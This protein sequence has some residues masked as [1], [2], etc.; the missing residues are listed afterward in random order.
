MNVHVHVLVHEIA[1]MVSVMVR[2]YEKW[3]GI[4]PT[5]EYPSSLRDFSVGLPFPVVKTTGF[6][7]F[8]LRG[9]YMCVGVGICSRFV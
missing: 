2:D 8:P 3:S 9:N 5:Q 1:E 7:T 6:M 4:E